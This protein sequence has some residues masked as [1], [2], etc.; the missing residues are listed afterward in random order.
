MR[1]SV[2]ICTY[3]PRRDYLERTLASLRAQT[4]PLSQWEF[5]L[6]DN[7]SPEP[8]EKSVDLSWHPNGRVVR[9]M[10]Q[11]LT[12]ARLRGLRETSAPLIAYIDDDNVLVPGYFEQA[13]RHFA[14]KPDLGA[15]GGKCIAEY[16]KAP[17]GWFRSM[18]GMIACRDFGE[19]PLMASWKSVPQD[20]REYPKCSP[21]GA[22]MVLR[23]DAMEAYAKALESD[24]VRQKLDR[25]GNSLA[26]GGDN[27]IVMTTLE[28]GWSVGYFPEL[29]LQHLIPARRV[30]ESYLARLTE[31]STRTW[32]LVLAAHGVRPWPPVAR[33]SL[34]LR[35]ARA[36]VACRAWKGGANYLRFRTACGMFDGR[37]QI[38]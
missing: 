14:E 28:Q 24:T 31:D 21:V 27:D 18:E 29:S 11:G 5:V 1:L 15:I 30:E 7:A 23:R 34:P 20:K 13:L 16:E 33:W 36:Y 6:V 9:E 8:L 38:S 35:K 25:T 37:S 3:N 26:S 32:V 19:A 4:L 10:K 12:P 22:G 17:P 2:V